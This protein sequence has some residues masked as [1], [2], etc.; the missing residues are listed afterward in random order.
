MSFEVPGVLESDAPTLTVMTANLWNG[1]AP[2]GKVVHA[3]RTS[4]ADLIGLEELN[5]R[6]ARVVVEAVADL[7][8]HAATFGDSHEGRGVLSKLP[9]EAVEPVPIVPDRP[10]V[11]AVVTV[12]GIPVTMIVGHPRPQMLKRGRLRFAMASLRQIISLGQLAMASGPAI[13]LGDFNMGPRHPGYARLQGLGLVDAYVT[14][15][16][17]ARDGNTFPLRVQLMGGQRLPGQSRIVPLPPLK[18]FD[19]IWHTPDMQTE[20]AWIGPDSGS[21][22]ASVVARLLLPVVAR[23]PQV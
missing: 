20:R 10:D 16:L 5:Q 13:L 19:H 6:Q 18:R 4:G 21:D 11:R 7:Y 17:A 22:H 15:G 8:P 3:L 2:D 23:Q 1:L 14:G 9:L 12:A